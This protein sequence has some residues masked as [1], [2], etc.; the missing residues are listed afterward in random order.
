MN[1][2]LEKVLRSVG[3]DTN[4]NSLGR[5]MLRSY[6]IACSATDGSDSVK[7]C[8]HLSDL[9]GLPSTEDDDSDPCP[10]PEYSSEAKRWMEAKHLENMNTLLSPNIDWSPSGY[11]YLTEEALE[12]RKSEGCKGFILL[13]EMDVEPIGGNSSHSGIG[14]SKLIEKMKG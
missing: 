11:E 2:Y 9:S 1:Q 4:R 10:Y 6:I 14:K 3:I 5:R 7:T 13:D 8:L 12:R